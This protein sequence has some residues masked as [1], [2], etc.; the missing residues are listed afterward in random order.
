MGRKGHK[1]QSSEETLTN[2]SNVVFNFSVSLAK[3]YL[4][5]TNWICNFEFSCKIML[6]FYLFS[7]YIREV[8]E[9]TFSLVVI[10]S[11]SIPKN[12]KTGI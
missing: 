6:K 1:T 3:L 5:L 9:E 4:K 11:Y 12:P 10:L 7:P 8:K 2:Q